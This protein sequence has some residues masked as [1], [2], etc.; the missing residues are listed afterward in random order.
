MY[1]TCA[2]TPRIRRKKDLWD[3]DTNGVLEARVVHS[4]REVQQ[5]ALALR[6]LEELFGYFG[7]VLEPRSERGR[8]LEVGARTPDAIQQDDDAVF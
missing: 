6:R 1:K 4:S 3:A 2:R 8:H 7:D 5:H